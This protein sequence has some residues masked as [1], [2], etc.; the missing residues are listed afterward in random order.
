MPKQIPPQYERPLF[1]FPS[2]FGVLGGAKDSWVC[3]DNCIALMRRRSWLGK[4]LRQG[5]KIC[6]GPA[7]YD[8]IEDLRVVSHLGADQDEVII[9]FKNGSPPVSLKTPRKNVE[10]VRSIITPR[11]RVRSSTGPRKTIGD[12]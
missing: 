7:F 3:W 5:D 10:F 12:V 2:R 9:T 11:L 6:W 4:L 1:S 8:Q